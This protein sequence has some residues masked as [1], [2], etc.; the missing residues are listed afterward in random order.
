MECL[1]RGI[2]PE[3]DDAPKSVRDAVAMFFEGRRAKDDEAGTLA[4]WS[5]DERTK[6][7][8]F[9]TIAATGDRPT[10]GRRTANMCITIA[11]QAEGQSPGRL[12]KTILSLNEK[13][14]QRIRFVQGKFNMGGSG[15]L[16]F[17]GELGLQLVISRRHPE[18]AKH[19]RKNDPT[20]E[21]WA[22][23]VVRREEP[24]N[25]SGDPIHSEFT[26]LAPLTAEKNPRKG[27]VIRFSAETMP[28]MPEHNEPYKRQIS[29]GTAIKLYEFDATVGRSNVLLP[30]GLLF[31]L[32]RL[33]PEIALPIRIHEC[34]GY[35]GEKERSFETP[36][37]GL[38]V[39]LEDG[40]GDNLEPKFP[41]T[42]MLEVGG[43]KMTA[44]IY[45]FKEDRAQTYLRD[46][47]VIFSINGQGHG[48]LPKS[49]FTRPKAVGLPRLKDSIL[50]L[51]DCS[52][53]TAIQ[54]ENLFMSSRDRLSKKPIRYALE[55]EIELLLKTNPDLRRLQQERREHDV[56]SALSDDK[57]LEEVLGRIL[58]ASPT[59]RALFLQGRRLSRPFAGGA[60][61]GNGNDDG[62]REGDK[63]FR[64]RRHPTYFKIPEVAE[65]ELYRRHCE[66]S[67]R[68][69]ISFETDV[70][71]DYFD[72]VTDRGKFEL[73]IVDSSRSVSPPSFSLALED[74]FAHLNMALPPE[75]EVGD[76]IVLQATVEDPTLVEPLVS[77]IKL[78]VE[79][80][81]DHTIS[82]SKKRK[83]QHGGEGDGTSQQGIKLPTPIVV[84]E[85][86]DNWRRHHF[87]PA[88][89]CHV[90]SDPVE[91]DGATV[92]DHTFYIN[93][94][95][96]SLKT[97]MKY[98]K[99]NPGLLEAKFK[100]ANVLLGLAMLHDAER[101]GRLQGGE[102]HSAKSA[103][104]AGNGEGESVQDAIRRVSSAIAPVLLPI[105]D[106]L[107]GLTEEQVEEIS[108]SGEDV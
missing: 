69:R 16:R 59:L 12:P 5:K 80:K 54:R 66:E 104:N 48:Y 57:P 102:D 6:Q 96:T 88:T 76:E 60:S 43:M 31:A 58:S 101:N 64:G 20:V 107:S 30:D 45:A 78:T 82:A 10:Q 15:A 17:C 50:V 77:M 3:S 90:I 79:S 108:A 18:L 41:L 67:R 85:N 81:H 4:N 8:R 52:S 49:L 35:K 26:Y 29:W 2:D 94:D 14:K 83:K 105:I 13:N 95:N 87:G 34:R 51:V 38:V 28:L 89:A 7:S 103:S 46:E 70:E 86:D 27:E 9:I 84:H 61:G 91:V 25:K 55:Q 93:V 33:L 74:G 100:Y 40:R 11:D 62:V 63:N 1:L 23:T 73:D 39:R 19:E 92:L 53:L 106:Q 97:E 56:Q 42:A 75:A 44:R 71:N 72:R 68:C 47:G 21:D 98:S 37:A 36:I 65:G 99:Q 24:S 32:E 22:I